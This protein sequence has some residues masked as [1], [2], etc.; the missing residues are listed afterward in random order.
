MNKEEI[1]AMSR[2]E[3]KGKDIEKLE[4]DKNANAIA[5]IAA[6]VCALVLFIAESF[7]FGSRIN[8]SLWAVI[9]VGAAAEQ[10]FR[11]FRQHGKRNLVEAIIFSLLSIVTIVAAI[12][13]FKA[14]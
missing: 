4:M 11:F 6:S 12:T 14:A 2:N 13:S 5:G 3:N 7:I 1:L 8:Y 10:W 9:C